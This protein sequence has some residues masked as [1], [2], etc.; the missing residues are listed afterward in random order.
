[1][2]IADRSKVRLLIGT[3]SGDGNTGANRWDPV[4]SFTQVKEAARAEASSREQRRWLQQDGGSSDESGISLDTVLATKSPAQ[5]S[6]ERS[7]DLTSVPMT[8]FFFCF[9]FCH[10][11][12]IAI[13][14]SVLI[15]AAGCA[16]LPDFARCGCSAAHS[17]PA[18]VGTC[19]FV[20]SDR[21]LLANCICADVVQAYTA[22]QAE[23]NA[24]AQAREQHVSEQ[25]RQREH[26]QMMEQISRINRSE[27]SL[28]QNIMVFIRG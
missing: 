22:R 2:S 14:L 28:F 27:N 19:I 23:A 6:C 24:A 26:E 16:L 15:G 5:H 9:F 25:T 10:F 20:L 7:S 12:Q 1:M 8:F 4:A 13:V 3:R 11:L 18:L 21:E 17:A